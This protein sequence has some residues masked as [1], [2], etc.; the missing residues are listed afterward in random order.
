[1]KKKTLKSIRRRDEFIEGYMTGKYG[2]GLSSIQRK[3]KIKYLEDRNKR[4]RS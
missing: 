3:K 1:M 2:K 4:Y